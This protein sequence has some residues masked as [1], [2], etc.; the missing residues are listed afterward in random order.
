M[1]EKK[2][3]GKKQTV[4]VIGSGGREHAIGWKLARS[5]QVGKL[6][7]AP[8]NPGTGEIGENVPIKADDIEGLVAFA[9]TKNIDITV[10]GTEASLVAGIVDRFAKDG[11]RIF[12]PNKQAARLETSKAWAVEFMARHG[13]P[14]PISEIFDHPGE[15]LAYAEKLGGRCVVKADGLCQGK[16]VFVCNWQEEA[17]RAVTMLMVDKLFGSAG[18]RVVIQEKLEGKEVSVMAFCDGSRAV[19]LV[20][21]QDYK[22]AY[23]GDHG[24][25]T[26]SMGSAAP[27][28]HV[29]PTLLKKIH[30]LLTLAVKGMGDEGAAYRGI[31]YAGLMIVD[32]KPYILEFNCRFGDPETQVQLPLLETDLLPILEACIDGRLTA[33]MVRWKKAS[34]VCVVLASE[35]YPG[36]YKTGEIVRGLRQ[37]AGNHGFMVFHA[38]TS[39]FGTVV[40]SAGGRVLGVTATAPTARA[41]RKKAYAAIGNPLSFEGMQY[42]KDIGK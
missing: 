17:R 40:Q 27:A 26:G 32:G 12:G 31:L 38:G 10:V 6:Y 30:R 15:A 7:F 1:L 42:R 29:G 24:P 33:E 28:K 19:P 11:F 37:P 25:N 5:L 13:V 36:I 23:D 9:K 41:A 34:A 4:L 8:G 21:V 39:R 20:A 35:G 2:K 14:H 22:R 18:D 16:G 3:R